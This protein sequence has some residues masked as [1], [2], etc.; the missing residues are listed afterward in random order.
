MKLNE[1]F[2]HNAMKLTILDIFFQIKA[3]CEKKDKK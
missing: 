1:F 3:L 2:W